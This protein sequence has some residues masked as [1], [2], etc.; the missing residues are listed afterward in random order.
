MGSHYVYKAKFVL[1]LLIWGNKLKRLSKEQIRELPVFQGV[2]LDKIEVV[3]N[4]EEALKAVSELIK[5]SVLGFDTESKPTFKKGEV[6]N[7]PQLIQISCKTKTFI[8][9]A[10]FPAAIKEIDQ[11]LSNPNIKKVGF[12]LADDKRIIF[13]KFGIKV[14]NTVELSKKVKLFLGVKQN[15]GARVAVAM[16]FNQR[17]TKSAQKSNWSIFP[18]K[19]YQLRYAANDAYAALCVETKIENSDIETAL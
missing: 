7:G 15:V 11:I 2:V 17:L 14:V 8:F 5:H 18:L 9:P 19:D 16:L 4:K 12:G 10:K 3:I 1:L 6:S 13:R